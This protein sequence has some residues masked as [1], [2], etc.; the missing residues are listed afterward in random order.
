MLCAPEKDHLGSNFDIRMARAVQAKAMLGFEAAC[1]GRMELLRMTMGDPVGFGG[2]SRMQ[3][4]D[5][6]A[7]F[8]CFSPENPE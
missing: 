6:G 5:S 3:G 8:F 7:Y 1:L 2:F 4:S